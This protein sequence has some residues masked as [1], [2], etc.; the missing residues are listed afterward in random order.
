VFVQWQGSWHA[1]LNLRLWTEKCTTGIVEKVPEYYTC[2]A[3][4]PNPIVVVQS[5]TPATIHARGLGAA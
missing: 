1:V 3:L 4:G 5:P 2:T